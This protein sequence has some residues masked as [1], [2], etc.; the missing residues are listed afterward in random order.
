MYVCF[1]WQKELDWTGL[2][3]ANSSLPV[4][5]LCNTKDLSVT[6]LR[7]CCAVTVVSFENTCAVPVGT[8]VRKE[9]KGGEGGLI[10]HTVPIILKT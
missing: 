5:F 2:G 1:P 7:F 9:K 6:F 4:I 3:C 8:C 10:K